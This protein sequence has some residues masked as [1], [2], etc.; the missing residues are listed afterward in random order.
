MQFPLYNL[1]DWTK[2]DVK[3][4]RTDDMGLPN[5]VIANTFMTNQKGVAK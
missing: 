3:I 4:Q 1:C 5:T 2:F